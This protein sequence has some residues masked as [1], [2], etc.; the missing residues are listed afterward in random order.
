MNRTWKLHSIAYDTEIFVLLTSL[1]GLRGYGGG[2]QVYR[3]VSDE[4]MQRRFT[5]TKITEWIRKIIRNTGIRSSSSSSSVGREQRHRTLLTIFVSRWISGHDVDYLPPRRRRQSSAVC[6]YNH[7]YS[8]IMVI[9]R[10]WPTFIGCS[11]PYLDSGTVYRSQGCS[12][13]FKNLDF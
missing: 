12:L 1:I 4:V 3:R 11:G 5:K 2:Y 6:G 9:N 13:D 10:R 7:L 8:P